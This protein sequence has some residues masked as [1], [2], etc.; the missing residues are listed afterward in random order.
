MHSD[1]KIFLKT[2]INNHF[3]NS[4]TFFLNVLNVYHI[5]NLYIFFVTSFKQNMAPQKSK[6]TQNFLLAEPVAVCLVLFVFPY[7]KFSCVSI[8]KLCFIV[9]S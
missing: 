6:D 1:L 9:S 5:L 8:T 2:Q 4:N 7:C 3:P